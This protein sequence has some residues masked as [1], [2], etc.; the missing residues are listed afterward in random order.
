MALNAKQIENLK[1]KDKSFAIADQNGLS[2]RIRPSG[3]KSWIYRFRYGGKAD[4]LTLGSYPLMSLKQA[5]MRTVQLASEL[6]NGTSPREYIRQEKLEAQRKGYTVTALWEEFDQI[7]ISKRQRPEQPRYLAVK[8]ILPI[9]GKIPCAN[10]GKADVLEIF[11]PLEKTP[12]ACESVFSL[13]KLL[14]TFGVNRGEV[15]SDAI[16]GLRAKDVGGSSNKRDRNLAFAEIRQL[17]TII[18]KSGTSPTYK[19]AIT[20]TLASGQR[21]STVLS[22]RWSEFDMAARIWTIPASSE[23]RYTKSKKSR[24]LP[25]SDFMVSILE[26]Q[27][28]YVPARWKCVFPKQKSD[29]PPVNTSVNAVIRQMLKCHN[30][31]GKE[32]L[33]HFHPHAL[34]DTF[35]SRLAELGQPYDIVERTVGHAIAGT[36]A[37]YLHYDFFNEQLALLELWGNKLRELS[38]DNVVTIEERK[39]F[40]HTQ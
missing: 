13:V 12:G 14:L 37:H 25:L 7:K 20:M 2:L 29:E 9:I 5:R 34:R 35:V 32:K 31:D 19:N 8:Y 22:A 15:R 4:T 24:K 16:F 40:Q 1:P 18:E 28:Q 3:A 30:D 33:E 36:R 27:R 39:D 6:E 17:L 38:T 23:E 10:L 21:I 11:R 26:H